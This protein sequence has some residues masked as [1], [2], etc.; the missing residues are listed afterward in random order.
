[1]NKIRMTLIISLSVIAVGLLGYGIYYLF[2]GND[3]DIVNTN[4]EVVSSSA[5]KVD[6]VA[7]KELDIEITND[8]LPDTNGVLTEID[9]ETF[10]SLFTTTKRSILVLVSNT[11]E[12]CSEYLPELKMVM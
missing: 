11:C 9:Y 5:N 10:E 2:K 12:N 1:M 8:N 3:S 6:Q 7:I 4:L